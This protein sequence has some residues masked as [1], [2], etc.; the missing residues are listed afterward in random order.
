LRS[1]YLASLLVEAGIDQSVADDA[2]DLLKAICAFMPAVFISLAAEDHRSHQDALAKYLSEGLSLPRRPIAINAREVACWQE[3]TQE[4]SRLLPDALG[5]PP[6]DLS[7]SEDVLL[8]LPKMEVP[9]RDHDAITALLTRYAEIV[10]QL[11]KAD[12][13]DVLRR[14][15]DSGRRW[16][17]L[18]EVTVPVG[19]RFAVTLSEDRPLKLEHKKRSWQRLALGDASSAHLEVRVNDTNVLLDGSL[20]CRDLLGEQVGPGLLEAVR[21][22]D[23]AGSLYSSEPERPR[24]A[25]VE[26]QLRLT[27]DVRLIPLVV[28]LLAVAATAITLLLPAS[29]NLVPGLTVVAVPITVAAALLAVRE[30]T[31]L[32]SRLQTM[33]RAVVVITTI[34][35]W[36]AVLLRLLWRGAA[37]PPWHH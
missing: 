31:A 27:R 24:Y 5:E 6:S 23:E 35:L 10:E 4:A 21:L 9:P 37:L 22:T 1:D 7:S 26:I 20:P 19:E 32:A 13:V 8:A 2:R 28:A 15:G 11:A 16:T 33:P 17:V 36:A 34:L 14:I 29:T 25:E 12:A 3:I 18:A 30:Q